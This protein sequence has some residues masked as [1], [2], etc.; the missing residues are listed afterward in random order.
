MPQLFE[1]SSIPVL[2][3]QMVYKGD[4]ISRKPSFP[5][6]SEDYVKVVQT[7]TELLQDYSADK[8]NS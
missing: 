1:Q 4:I 2:K 3:I 7:I 5:L 6:A 8:N